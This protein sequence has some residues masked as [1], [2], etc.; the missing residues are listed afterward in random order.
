MLRT[1]LLVALALLVSACGS[2]GGAARERSTLTVLA[3]SSLSQTLPALGRIFEAGHP[4]TTVV[5]SFA[6]S[7]TLAQQIRSGAPADVFAAASAVTM[8]QVVDAGDATDPRVFAT[9]QA[10]IAVYPPSAD[11]V[12]SLADLARPGLRVSLCQPQVPCGVL[13]VKVLSLAGVRV[14]P[15]TQGLDVKSTLAS[16]LSGETDAAIVYVTDVRAAGSRVVGIDIPAQ[17][18]AAT[19]YEV[20]PLAVSRQQDLARAFADLLLAAGSQRVLQAAG[21]QAP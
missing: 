3:A 13:A 11:K 14:T 7:T 15:V 12:R 20:A 1:P 6:A 19:S 16:V 17:V 10:Q 2:S 5:F 18:N 8:K 21:F 4:G 9:N